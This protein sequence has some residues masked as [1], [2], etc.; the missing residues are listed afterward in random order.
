MFFKNK[1]PFKLNII[2]KNCNIQGIDFDG[3]INSI[4]GLKEARK[5]DLTF[6]ENLIYL[7]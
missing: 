1:G 6:L 2:K 3:V 5:D 7:Y 4:K